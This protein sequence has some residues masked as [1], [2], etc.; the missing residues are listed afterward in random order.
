M[1]RSILAVAAILAVLAP[2][3]R[4]DMAAAP[5]SLNK[6][7]SIQADVVV[8]GDLFSGLPAGKADVPVAYAPKLGRSAILD[9]A[10]LAK[11][12]RQQ[13]VDWRPSSRFE[14]T[15]VERAS[16]AIPYQVIE[17]AIREE[18]RAVEPDRVMDVRFDSRRTTLHIPRS[19]ERAVEI[20]QFD[21][22][23]R[24]GRFAALVV[25]PAGAPVAE[26]KVYGKTYEVAEIPVLAH[27]VTR[28]DVISKDDIQWLE[29][30]AG[31]IGGNVVVDPERLVGM[32]P[33]RLLQPGVPVRGSDLEEP[34][35]VTRGSYVTIAVRTDLMTLTVRGRAVEN[36]SVGKPVQVMNIQSKQVVEAIVVDAG[37]VVVDTASSK[38]IN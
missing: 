38:S 5:V 13:G 6:D 22:D 34:V 11:V 17:D 30:N 7:V 16:Q 20:R 27:R 8:L 26:A 14:R 2:S 24:T 4:A 32:T 23:A 36:G 29:V 12:A 31:R 25:A 10:W 1:F 35:A 28:G 19:A 18:M 9:A 21:Y 15:T 37:T 3:A 33:R